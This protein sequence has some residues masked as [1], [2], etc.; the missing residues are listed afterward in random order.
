MPPFPTSNDFVEEMWDISEVTPNARNARRHSED[1]I[2]RI[3]RSIEEFGFTVPVLVDENGELIAGHGRVLG[4]ERLGMTH[5]PVRIARGWTEDQKR[6][7]LLADNKIAEGAR[8][9]DAILAEELT[10]LIESD[11][12]ATLSGF[13]EKEIDRILDPGDLPVIREIET[14]PVPDR[15]WISIRGPLAHQAKVLDIVK[16]QIDSLDDIELDVGAVALGA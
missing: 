2:L 5:I 11:Y 6:A 3:A 1:Q 7:Y 10:A 4:A 14:G 12:D 13:T 16:A 15:F 9:D 8:W